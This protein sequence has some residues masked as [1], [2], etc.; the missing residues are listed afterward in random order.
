[1]LISIFR[2]DSDKDYKLISAIKYIFEEVD[3][4]E[5][6]VSEHTCFKMHKMSLSA[7]NDKMY[8]QPMYRMPRTKAKNSPIS[9]ASRNP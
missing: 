1:M 3:D 6:Q 7:W 2:V 9:H 5:S 8:S 4:H